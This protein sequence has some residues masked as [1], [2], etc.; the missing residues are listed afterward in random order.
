VITEAVADISIHGFDS[1]MR[2]LEW[3]DRIRRAALADLVPESVLDAELRRV[4][5]RTYDR[6]VEKGAI[7]V[8]H[9]DI[10][11]F[12]LDRVKPKLRAELDRRIMAS[13]GLIKLNRARSVEETLQ[14][15][16]GWATSIPPGG[17]RVVEKVPVKSEIRK[18]LASLPFAERRCILDQS[19]KLISAVSNIIAT[20]GGAIA[21]IWHDHGHNDK[22]YNAR[23]E[24]LARDGRV[25]LIRDNWAQ[26]LGLCKVGAAGY[27]DQITAPGEEISCKCWYEYLYGIRRL[28]DDMV[29]QQGRDSLALNTAA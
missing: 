11:K 13:T 7:L 20:D 14:R 18:A 12:T 10:S 23:P 24:H 6:Y 27:M 15:F 5:A 21:G 29:T 28:P 4:L 3:L 26:K 22:G 9:G 17:S 19:R 16:Q 2:L 25:F 8:R 1:E